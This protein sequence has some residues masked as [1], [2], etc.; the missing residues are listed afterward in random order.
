M[1][2][3]FGLIVG[4]IVGWNFLTQP[5]WVKKLVDKV[6]TKVKEKFNKS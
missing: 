6:V 1:T 4:L 5:Q 3:L 2:F